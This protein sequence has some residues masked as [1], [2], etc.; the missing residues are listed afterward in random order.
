MEAAPLRNFGF[1]GLNLTDSDEVVREGQFVDILNFEFSTRPGSLVRR[2][3]FTSKFD[4]ESVT[5]GLTD[6]IYQAHRYY[7]WQEDH[8]WIARRENRLFDINDTFTGGTDIYTLSGSFLYGDMAVMNNRAFIVD[9][10]EPL[11]YN[12]TTVRQMGNIAPTVAPVVATAGAGPIPP[13]TYE[14]RMRN[15]YSNGSFSNA[16]PVFT[17]VIPPGPNV[18]VNITDAGVVPADVTRRFI[19]RTIAGPGGD[20]YTVGSY[21]LPAGPPPNLVDTLTDF[22]LGGADAPDVL[23]FCD[24]PLPTFSRIAAFHPAQRMWA[25]EGPGGVNPQIAYYSREG[26]PENWMAD[27]TQDVPIYTEREPGQIRDLERGDG[28][29]LTALTALEREMLFWS[30]SSF[31]RLAGR[32]VA[33]WY[34]EHIAWTGCV[35][36]RTVVP[37]GFGGI[38]W[39][40]RGDIYYYRGGMPVP[41]SRPVEAVVRNAVESGDIS[42]AHAC[43]DRRGHWYELFLPVPAANGAQWPS[44]GTHDIEIWHPGQ[45]TFTIPSPV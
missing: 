25:I 18:T 29:P 19:E 11:Q 39:L 15:Q 6:G 26:T 21:V 22:Q 33:N 7:R 1:K 30:R 31:Y 45:R 4:V 34:L 42:E 10:N 40:G 37:D 38:L 43:L 8:R 17:L 28:S 44:G 5:P 13:G 20:F 32:S 36:P 23:R 14:Y 12:G 9:G 2:P 16:G 3:G 41:I 27:A 35:A 24:E